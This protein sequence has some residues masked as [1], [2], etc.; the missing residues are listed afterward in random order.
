MDE[1]VEGSRVVL[2]VL[3]WEDSREMCLKCAKSAKNSG[4]KR[5]TSKDGWGR[6]IWSSDW[7]SDWVRES[8]HNRLAPGHVFPSPPLSPSPVSPA[9][10][11]SAQLVTLVS[12]AGREGRAEAQ[13]LSIELGHR[14]R[15]GVRPCLGGKLGLSL[16]PWSLSLDNDRIIVLPHFQYEPILYLSLNSQP[17]SASMSCACY[18]FFVTHLAL[19]TGQDPCCDTSRCILLQ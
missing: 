17:T 19:R 16:N 14:G 2:W 7:V 8:V 1:L 4:Y 3:F 10:N 11:R 12:E 5:W 18:F 6:G 15:V 13:A 9:D